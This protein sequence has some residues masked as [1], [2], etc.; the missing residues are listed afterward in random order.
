MTSKYDTN[1]THA[2]ALAMSFSMT[3][4][5]VEYSFYNNLILTEDAKKELDTLYEHLK[6]E[7]TYKR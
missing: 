2:H 1:D 4:L 3:K 6:Q 7:I 5:H